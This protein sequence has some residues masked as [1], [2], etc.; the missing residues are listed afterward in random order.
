M[1]VISID[2]LQYTTPTTSESTQ[3]RTLTSSAKSGAAG[4]ALPSAS[5]S[6]STSLPGLVSAFHGHEIL[7]YEGVGQSVGIV[8]HWITCRLSLLRVSLSAL[9][10]IHNHCPAVKQG[11]VYLVTTP[12]T[13]PLSGKAQ[14]DPF[15]LHLMLSTTPS[16]PPIT[17]INKRV[18]KQDSPFKTY[19]FECVEMS[20]P[21]STEIFGERHMVHPIRD[22]TGCAVALVDLTLTPIQTLSLDRGQLREITKVLNLLTSTFYYLS[23]SW[24]EPRFQLEEEVWRGL[25]QQLTDTEDIG[26]VGEGDNFSVWNSGC[27]SVLCVYVCV[28]VCVRFRY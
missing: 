25:K 21:F 12:P 8:H 4:R 16:A 13:T 24:E 17:K 11:E 6:S 14:P 5:T 22:N 10:W 15:L 18:N 23:S 19:L 27:G 3:G 26:S 2:T 7:F 1:G 28:Y 9:R 20:E